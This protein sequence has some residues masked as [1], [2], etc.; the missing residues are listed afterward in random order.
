MT[1]P[2]APTEPRPK[3]P[4]IVELEAKTT[5]PQWLFGPHWANNG[6]CWITKDTFP[7]H[8]GDMFVAFHGSW[9]DTTLVGYR[10]E[11]VL[12]DPL[13]GR[14]YGSQR[15]V[16][17]IDPAGRPSLA[18]PVD[19]VECPDGSI[20]FSVDTG[21]NRRGTMGSIYRISPVRPATP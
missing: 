17:T 6:F 12:F 16:S 10:I 15:I 18:S 5:P 13:T 11:H 7:N 19:C 2:D 9:N 4:T 1:G 14:P 21:V 20:L 8:K 3:I